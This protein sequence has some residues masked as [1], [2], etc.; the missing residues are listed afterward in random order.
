MSKNLEAKQQVVN[1][2]KEKLQKS[3]SVLLVD[4]KGINVEDVT[5]LRKRFREAGVDYKVYKNTLFKRAAHEAGIEELNEFLE[6]TVGYVFG[7]DDVVAP[8]KTINQFQ[9]DNPKTPIAVK[10][11]FVENSF[12]DADAVKALGDLP[13]REVLI[14]MLLGALQGSVRN[15]A[16]M[17]NSIKEKKE[18]EA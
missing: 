5:E 12:M 13:S 17:L 15:L 11:G 9:K 14:A 8:A 6:G 18:A 7:Y 2:V 3:K 10:A 16:Y 4:Y 1:E